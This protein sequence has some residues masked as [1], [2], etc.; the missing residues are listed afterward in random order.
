MKI[1]AASNNEIIFSLS[2]YFR[3][4]ENHNLDILHREN[5]RCHPTQALLIL[6]AMLFL[7]LS[8]T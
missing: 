5:L 1:E 2:D 6:S 4:P 7:S 3:N 8:L